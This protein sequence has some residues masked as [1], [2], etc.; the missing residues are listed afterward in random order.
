MWSC[1]CCPEQFER[2]QQFLKH[3]RA[4]HDGDP[5]FFVNCVY[6]HKTF[7]VIRAYQRHIAWHEFKEQ[8]DSSCSQSCSRSQSSDFTPEAT[9]CFLERCRTVPVKSTVDVADFV[10]YLQSKSVPKKICE[11]VV[12]FMKGFGEQVVNEVQETAQASGSDT[13]DSK[14]LPSIGR[15]YTVDTSHKMEEFAKH[16]RG[17]ISPVPHRGELDP[18]DLRTPQYVPIEGQ[19]KHVLSND[20]K[21]DKIDWCPKSGI[22][23]CFQGLFDGDYHR[24]PTPDTLYLILYYDEFVV[25]NPL[26]NKT[27]KH[28]I[29]AIYYTIGN[30][31]HRSQLNDI[32]LAMLFP[33]SY[34][35]KHTWKSLLEPLVTDLNRLN[36]D[37]MSVVM[38]GTQKNVKCAVA[39]MTGDNKGIHEVAGYFAAFYRTNRICRFCHATTSSIQEH[40]T[41]C[42]FDMRTKEEYDEEIRRLTA[43]GYPDNMQKMFGIKSECP[44]NELNDFHCISHFPVDISHDLF[45]NGVAQHTVQHVLDFFVFEDVITS[46]KVNEAIAEFPYHRTDKNRPSVFTTTGNKL[47][48]SETCSE[49]WT[50]LRLMPLML[51][52]KMDENNIVGQVKHKW[53]LLTGLIYI[54]QRATA[55]TLSEGDL[56][57]LSTSVPEWLADFKKEFPEFKMKPKFHHLVHYAGQ[58]R[59]HGPLMSLS[60]LRF[61]AKHKQMKQYLANSKN[62]MNVCKSMAESHQISSCLQLSGGILCEEKNR[63]SSQ[64]QQTSDGG[65]GVGAEK[66]LRE[67]SVHGM[68]YFSKDVLLMRD[69]AEEVLLVQVQ[70]FHQTEGSYVMVGKKLLLSEAVHLVQGYRVTFGETIVRD[71]RFVEHYHAMG[72][73]S[74]LGYHYVIPRN[75]VLRLL[76]PKVM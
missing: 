6:C 69:D 33:S 42:D 39:Y 60:S 52:T 13:V 65:D 58:W 57:S 38:N 11:D 66:K 32:H 70:H 8:R 20:V 22:T 36:S 1:D 35:K 37:G 74:V 12:S 68:V 46:E 48:V 21:S 34:T 64:A 2:F 49:M 31:R 53:Q 59:K 72:L 61:E 45:E 3:L 4:K 56:E 26:G 9:P 76:Q 19:L 27:A 5:D 23:G 14:R 24:N 50:L 40:F 54:A 44:L 17:Y 18:S 63:R 55:D 51:L 28:T 75:D 71:I 41:E 47:R 67:A 25:S 62:R 16:E 29:G 73:Y 43:Q 15:L 7:K 10:L 30:M